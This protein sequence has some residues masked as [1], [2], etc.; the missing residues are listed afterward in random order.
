MA[1]TSSG[2]PP[3]DGIPGSNLGRLMAGNSATEQNRQGKRTRNILIFSMTIGVALIVLVASFLL[4]GE[5]GYNRR[6]K[7]SQNIAISMIYNMLFSLRRG[8]W[9]REWAWQMTCLSVD[10]RESGRGVPVCVTWAGAGVP[11]PTEST[12][13]VLPSSK[14]K[15]GLTLY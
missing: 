6:A 4:A 5:N 3:T 9:Q 7:V 10:G 15:R 2:P 14:I 8:R 1:E 11:V 12:S 13:M